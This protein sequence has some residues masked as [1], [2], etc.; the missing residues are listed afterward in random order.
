M[1]ICLYLR[2]LA[3]P[4]TQVKY[5][6]LLTYFKT[7]GTV[8]PADDS[9]KVHNHSIASGSSGN[10]NLLFT[11]ARSHTRD[12]REICS[13]ASSIHCSLIYSVYILDFTTDALCDTTVHLVEYRELSKKPHRSPSSNSHVAPNFKEETA[14]SAAMKRW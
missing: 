7:K 3:L 1:H 12:L 10:K 9:S 11:K 8:M 5:R 6:K 2:R 13:R 14:D 4:L